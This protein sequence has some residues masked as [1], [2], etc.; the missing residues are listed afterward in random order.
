MPT[1]QQRLDEMQ[2]KVRSKADGDRVEYRMVQRAEMEVVARDLL[3]RLGLEDGAM[4]MARLEV[5]GVEH[6]LLEGW[7][8]QIESRMGGCNNVTVTLTIEVFVPD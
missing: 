2:D 8:E 7:R 1:M 4:G 5:Q 6:D 3:N